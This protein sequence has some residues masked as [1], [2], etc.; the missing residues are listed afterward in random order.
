MVSSNT[1]SIA[2]LLLAALSCSGQSKA[3]FHRSQQEDAALTEPLQ[4]GF[5]SK[6]E[7][8]RKRKLTKAKVSIFTWPAL[9]ERPVVEKEFIVEDVDLLKITEISLGKARIPVPKKEGALAGVLPDMQ[10]ELTTSEDSFKV[11]VFQSSFALS[12]EPLP[13]D[14]QREFTSTWLAYVLDKSLRDHGANGL[15]DRSLSALSGELSV[16]NDI[17][18]IK[19]MIKK[20]AVPGGKE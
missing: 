8:G 5:W 14:S 16:K 12:D 6:L 1:T 18:A 7:F 10:L 20:M 9:A 15:S 2:L 3:E 11:H 17:A 4:S 19:E 13:Y